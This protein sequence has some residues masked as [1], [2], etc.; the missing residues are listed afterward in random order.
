MKVVLLVLETVVELAAQRQFVFARSHLGADGNVR[1][2]NDD[3][4]KDGRA[5]HDHAEPYGADVR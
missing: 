1:G 4:E 2:E 5:E 3:G